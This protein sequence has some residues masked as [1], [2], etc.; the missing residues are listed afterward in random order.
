MLGTGVGHYIP[1]VAY[2]GFWVVCIASLVGRPLIGFY[3][4]I[5]FLPYRTMRDHFLVYPLG[6]NLLTILVLCVIVGAVLHGKRL[7]TS[8][9]YLTWLLIAL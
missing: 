4:M 3:Y 6:A 8:K 9:L 5:P 1:V 2:L 7:P